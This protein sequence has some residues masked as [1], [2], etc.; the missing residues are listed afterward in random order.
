M[1]LTEFILAFREKAAELRGKCFYCGA[2]TEKGLK[3]SAVLFQTMDHVIPKSTWSRKGPDAPVNLVD[4][5]A[6]RVV[7]CRKCND[8]KEDLTLFEFKRRSGIM[9]FFAEQTLGVLIDEL[10]DI[11]HWAKHVI[12]NRRVEGRTVKFHGKKVVRAVQMPLYFGKGEP[13]FCGEAT[14]AAVQQT[15]AELTG[16]QWLIL[17]RL[18]E[19]KY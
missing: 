14:P 5:H 18:A 13:I 17:W 16:E 7:C 8:L 15:F 6:N 1:I 2:Q 10:D 12:Y 4:G 9:T 3:E 11:D 19:Q